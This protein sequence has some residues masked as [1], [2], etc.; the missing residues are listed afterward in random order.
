MQAGQIA[1]RYF[2]QLETV[3]YKADN[4]LLTQAD[5]EIEQFLTEK[6]TAAFPDDGLIGEEGTRFQ[7][8]QRPSRL[9]AIDPLDGTTAFVKELPT[10]GIAI[11]ILEAGLPVFGLFYMPL[12]ND[13]TY[14]TPNG[15]LWANG[16][17]R[18]YT[19]NSNWQDKGY[20]AVSGSA[21]YNF[22]INVRRTFTLGSASASLVYT[23]RSSASAAFIPKARLW[24][25]VAGAAMIHQTQGEVCYLSGAAIDYLALL[26]GKRAPE[27]VIAGHPS[28][29][30]EIRQAIQYK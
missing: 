4:T 15:L 3:H 11:G 22:S 27:P 9:W 19:V 7:A 18:Q 5:L 26:D 6:I 21:H 29:L 16:Q 12:L 28:L 23:A 10:W 25:L 2:N 8:D 20:L 30:L 24:D 17:E 1:L 14:T 13:L